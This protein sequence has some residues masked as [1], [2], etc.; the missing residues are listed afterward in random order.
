MTKNVIIINTCDA[1]NDV[2]ELFFKAF[3][4]YWPRCEY[5]IILNTEKIKN[6]P[7]GIANKNITIHNFKKGDKQD[8]W[9]LRLKQTIES[10]DSKFITLLY[11]DFILEK[12][13]R[14]DQIKKCINWLSKNSEIAVF[15]LTHIPINKNIDVSKF[16]GFEL[17]PKRGDFKLNS[18]PSVWRREKLLKYLYDDD[19]PWAWEFF[20]SFRTY[21]N[22][23]LFYCLK[24]NNKSIYTYNDSMGGA[25]YRGK[26]VGEIV[27]PLLEKYNINLNIK[28]R[29]VVDSP[30]NTKRALSWKIK[31]FYLGFKMVKFG[32][33]V[34]IYR[35][36]RNK[37]RQT[38]AP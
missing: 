29:G 25:I 14:R 8:K 6:L 26:W 30:R 27:L 31:F 23:D 32:V 36:L 20:G 38:L 34:F 10:T 18:A 28:K 2:W 13:I 16:K 3:D 22:Q 12:P 11:D 35:I 15:Y 24:K 21:K 37:L 1:Y 19:N 9:G 7:H 17:M 5:P 33:L 4:E